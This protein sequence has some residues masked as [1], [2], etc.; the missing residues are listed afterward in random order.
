MLMERAAQQANIR[1]IEAEFIEETVR[2]KLW[3]DYQELMGARKRIE[4]SGHLVQNSLLS[5]NIIEGR[6]R[7]GVGSLA[8]VLQSTETYSTLAEQSF[9]D[10]VDLNL[11]HLRIATAIGRASIGNS[12]EIGP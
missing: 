5:L 12:L 7:S 10:I 4:Q 2:A 8:E 9:E 11:S 6:Y 3:S 1:L